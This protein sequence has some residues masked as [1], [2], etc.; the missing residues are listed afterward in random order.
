MTY[1]LTNDLDRAFDHLFRRTIGYDYLPDF[2]EN[3]GRKVPAM[4][5]FPPYDIQKIEDNRYTLTIALAGYSPQ[6]VEVSVEDERLFVKTREPEKTLT[7]VGTTKEHIVDTFIYKGIAKR[8]FN[9]SYALGEHMEVKGA[10]FVNGLLTIA[11][12]RIVPEE[13]KPRVIPII[14]NMEAP[15]LEDTPVEKA[16]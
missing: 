2:M 1:N 7:D 8:S 11:I 14:S 9:L 12:E 10:T 5:N 4:G 6:D 15:A 16:A 3:W 13:K